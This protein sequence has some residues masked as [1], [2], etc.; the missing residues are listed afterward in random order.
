MLK[1]KIILALLRAR[2]AVARFFKKAW[3]ATLGFFKGLDWK[4]WLLIAGIIL[5]AS[6]VAWG[7]SQRGQKQQAELE[8]R[9]AI[10]ELQGQVELRE[11]LYFTTAQESSNLRKQLREIHGE[12]SNLRKEI[13]HLRENPVVTTVTE[14][15]YR[16][17][18]VFRSGPEE[19]E[20]DDVVSVVTETSGKTGDSDEQGA[21]EN[22]IVAFDLTRRPFRITGQTETLGPVVHIELEQIEPFVLGAVLT[23][24][25]RTGLWNLYV[26][27]QSQQ[28]EVNISSF[29]VDPSVHSRRFL[30]RLGVGASVGVGSSSVMFSP[31]ASLDVGR[32]ASIWAGPSLMLPLG[33]SQESIWSER[34][35]GVST[36]FTFRPF[37]RNP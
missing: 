14:I 29:V 21:P 25:R 7:F 28:L 36:G 27:G 10:A 30:D 24:E 5:L 19:G 16:D 13:Q 2:R 32:R 20:E 26:E 6:S 15:R 35:L 23:R 31:H 11:G 12:N 34:S 17:R 1:T 33:E 9:R 4:G 37:A 22:H 3:M 18:V 8:S